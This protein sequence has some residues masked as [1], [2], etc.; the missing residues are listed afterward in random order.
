M[1]KQFLGVALAVSVVVGWTGSAA[2]CGGDEKPDESIASLCGGDDE[3]PDESIV[4]LCGGDHKDE[5]PDES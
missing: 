2:A 4:S 1:A 3:K 5:K